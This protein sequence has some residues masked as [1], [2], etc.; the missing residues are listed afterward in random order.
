MKGVEIN[1]FEKESKRLNFRNSESMREVINVGAA[2][3]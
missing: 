3:V 1:L 2:F